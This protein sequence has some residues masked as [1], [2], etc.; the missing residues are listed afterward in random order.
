MHSPTL[1]EFAARLEK[2]E[3]QNR[4]LKRF[5]VVFFGLFTLLAGW[6]SYQ[7]IVDIWR[8]GTITQGISLYRGKPFSFA[9]MTKLAMGGAVIIDGDRGFRG[10]IGTHKADYR[11][12]KTDYT[13]LY[14]INDDRNKAF[15]SVS[16]RGAFLRLEDST[17]AVFL[18]PGLYDDRQLLLELISQDGRQGIRLGLDG[19]QQPLFEVIQD[20]EAV[21]LLGRLV[22]ASPGAQDQ[23]PVR[24][25]SHE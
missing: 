16:E 8:P 21:S 12:H 6:M 18:G 7:H 13:G 22:S 2:V 20:G 1:D 14:F 5:G 23:A 4:R 10:N 9:E 19:D 17:N 3:R 25:V 15:L 24:E 11:G